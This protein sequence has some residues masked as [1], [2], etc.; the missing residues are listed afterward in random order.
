[1]FS[2]FL[3]A[4]L[5]LTHGNGDPVQDAMALLFGLVS[6]KCS[7]AAV[8]EA[9]RN[10]HCDVASPYPWE[11]L[12]GTNVHVVMPSDRDGDE[13]TWLCLCALEFYQC[14]SCADV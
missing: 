6:S 9:M 7:L 3:S 14:D 11:L 2:K 12:V 10:N 8:Y 13:G 4:A 1:M 5:F